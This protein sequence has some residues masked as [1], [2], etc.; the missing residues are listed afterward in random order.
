MTNLPSFREMLNSNVLLEFVE[1]DRTN[2]KLSS[3]EYNMAMNKLNSLA[4][5]PDDKIFFKNKDKEEVSLK[6]IGFRD[7]GRFYHLRP[8]DEMKARRIKIPLRGIG[9]MQPSCQ[10]DGIAFAIKRAHEEDDP[11]PPMVVLEDGVFYVQDGHHR[12]SAMKL[13]GRDYMIANVVEKR[14]DNFYVPH[15][16]GVQ[17]W[18]E[19]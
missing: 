10:R 17:E 4:K 13:A 1:A 12:T 11:K 15:K 7:H 2:E 16:A 5:V 9:R 8:T 14:G 3:D 6:D 18:Q 19:V